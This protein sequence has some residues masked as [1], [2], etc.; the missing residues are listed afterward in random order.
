[1]T[2]SRVKVVEVQERVLPTFV[3]FGE[4]GSVLRLDA[5]S[6]KY[7][8]DAGGWSVG[9]RERADGVLVTHIAPTDP[10]YH[11]HGVELQEATEQEWQDDNGQW[12]R[13]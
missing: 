3:R 9:F 8:R 2:L 11:V 12:A 7:H 1:M 5:Y 10:M 6:G 4:R 13:R